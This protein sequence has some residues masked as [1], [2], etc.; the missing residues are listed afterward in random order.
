MGTGH[1]D[2]HP[3]PA[4]HDDHAVGQYQFEQKRCREGIGAGYR[5]QSESAAL[6]SPVRRAGSEPCTRRLC[7]IIRENLRKKSMQ[8]RASCLHAFFITPFRKPEVLFRTA[9]PH[10]KALP[11]AVMASIGFPR[12]PCPQYATNRPRHRYRAVESSGI[13]SAHPVTLLNN[14]SCCRPSSKPLLPIPLYI[15]AYTHDWIPS[16]PPYSRISAQKKP[17]SPKSSSPASLYCRFFAGSHPGRIRKILPAAESRH[18]RT[19]RKS[20]LLGN[21]FPDFDPSIRAVGALYIQGNGPFAGLR[22]AVNGAGFVGSGP[23]AEIPAPLLDL[24]S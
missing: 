21:D 4:G 24:S 13:F 8:T 3:Q 18:D 11:L 15:N 12:T 1:R 5:K 6:V 9:S 23:V 20:R 22:I 16:R 10:Q 7:K 17:G 14:P 19:H 2:R